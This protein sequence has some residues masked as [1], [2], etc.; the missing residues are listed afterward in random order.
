M[1]NRLASMQNQV[2]PSIKHKFL[3]E[4]AP[5]SFGKQCGLHYDLIKMKSLKTN[6]MGNAFRKTLGITL[7]NEPVE[8]V[9]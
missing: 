1:L 4:I 8:N 9:Q 7:N 3:E 5:D 2:L 6:S